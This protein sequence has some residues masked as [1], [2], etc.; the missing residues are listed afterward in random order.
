MFSITTNLL[1]KCKFILTIQADF[2]Q[3]PHPLNS[4]N[5]VQNGGAGLFRARQKKQEFVLSVIFLAAIT[6]AASACE[7]GWVSTTATLADW[8]YMINRC[9]AAH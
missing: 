3:D 4:R 6:S 5:H 9:I 2:I 8:N 7:I 1:V